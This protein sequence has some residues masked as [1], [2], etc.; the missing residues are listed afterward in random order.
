MVTQGGQE[1]E[2]APLP[3]HLLW[4]LNKTTGHITYERL[5]IGKVGCILGERGPTPESVMPGRV[6]GP[7][8][9][10]GLGPALWAPAGWVQSP[11]GAALGER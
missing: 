5:R 8:P 6:R 7:R 3:H 2:A 1:G 4:L 9:R 11:G 10:G